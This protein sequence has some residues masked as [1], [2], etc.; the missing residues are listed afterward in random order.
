MIIGI[1][2][3]RRSGKTTVSKYL[4]AEHGFVAHNFKA[5]IIQEMKDKFP[6]TLDALCR[7]LEGANNTVDGLFEEKPRAMRALMQNFGTDVRRAEDPNYWVDKWSKSLPDDNVVVDD[8][9]FLNEADA[10]RL[11]GGVIIR[12]QNPDITSGGSHVTETEQEQ[13]DADFSL[14]A[15]MGNKIELFRQTESALEIM[16][17]NND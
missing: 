12:V 3:L 5:A 14:E 6:E 10:I 2:G 7:H 13:I 17:N 4:Q 9:R 11:L 1:T 15:E 16:K 8:V